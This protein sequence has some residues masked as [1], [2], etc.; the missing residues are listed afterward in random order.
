MVKVFKN[1][2]NTIK[3]IDAF[4]DTVQLGLLNFKEGVQH[5]LNGNQVE[6]EQKLNEVEKLEGKA[7]SIYRSI[8]NDFYQHSL[9]PNLSGDIL[10]LL[11]R[12]DDMIDKAKKS[13]SQFDVE[14]PHI[15]TQLK[16]D[17]NRLVEL[18]ILTT[19]HVIPACRI[20]FTDPEGVKDHVQKVLFYERETDKF[21]NQM[22]RKIFREMD[23]L[24]L[25]EKA[26]LRYFALHI[27]EISDVSEA[28][29]HIL[30]AMV[31]KI[32]M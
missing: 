28:V 22:K 31:L 17:F 18:S 27:E 25:S 20:F 30:S 26:H 15:P 16:V 13:L 7:D 24:K 14:N 11:D 32:R 21:A 3:S 8:E 23:E 5:F 12:S 9:L 29:A 2:N 19:E 6:F 4:Y 1:S 10:R